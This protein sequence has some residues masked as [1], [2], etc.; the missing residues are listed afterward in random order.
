MFHR[1]F[2]E[3]RISVSHLRR[4]YKKAQIKF[5]TIKLRK[6]IELVEPLRLQALKIE[7][8][9]KYQREIEQGSKILFLDE[10]VFTS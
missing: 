10:T 4:I 8:K 3:I 7:M 5:K 1:Q 2:P 6:E 9:T